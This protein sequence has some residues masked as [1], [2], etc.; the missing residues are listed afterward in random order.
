MIIERKRVIQEGDYVI[1]YEAYNCSN[2]KQ[3]SKGTTFT[4]RNGLYFLDQLIGK[5]YGTLVSK[6]APLSFPFPLLPALCSADA[7]SAL[8]YHL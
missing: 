1:L 6:D 7:S 8:Y 3:V 2:F 5:P 4:N